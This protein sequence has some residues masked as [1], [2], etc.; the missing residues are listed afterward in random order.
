MLSLII[1]PVIKI[2]E[3]NWNVGQKLGESIYEFICLQKIDKTTELA[4]I[5]KLALLDK[6]FLYSYLDDEEYLEV[7]EVN[8]YIN[9]KTKWWNTGS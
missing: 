5:K 1:I 9:D 7:K 4:L 8:D 6:D 2:I 3:D